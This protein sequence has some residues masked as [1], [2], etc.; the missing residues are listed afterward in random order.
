M[1]FSVSP[2]PAEKGHRVEFD[3]H[4]LAFGLLPCIVSKSI[5]RR[6][7]EVP[8]AIV[9]ECYSLR[10]FELAAWLSAGLIFFFARE[11]IGFAL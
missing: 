7:G 11:K 10:Q 1:T 9:V 2:S 8:P 5:K 4:C 6:R 3:I